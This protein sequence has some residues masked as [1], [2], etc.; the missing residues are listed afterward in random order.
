MQRRGVLAQMDHH[1]KVA[2]LCYQLRLRANVWLFL[3]HEKRFHK[4]VV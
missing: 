2:S 4:Y 3:Q 1:Q